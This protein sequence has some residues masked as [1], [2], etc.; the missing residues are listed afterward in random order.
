MEDP[1]AKAAATAK[2]SQLKNSLLPENTLS[3]RFT[4]TT[5]PELK[6]VSGTVYAGTYSGEE[7]RLLWVK[8]ADRLYPTGNMPFTTT[9]DNFAHVG[10]FLVYT[11]WRNPGIVPLLHTYTVVIEKLQGG[12]DLMTP[13]LAGGPPFPEK[14]KKGAIVAVASVDSPSV[15]LVI[16]TCEIDI[17]NLEQVQGAKGHAVENVHWA[18]DELWSWSSAGKPG[19]QPPPTIDGWLEG[20]NDEAELATKTQELD[21][22]DSASGG[23]SLDSG[24]TTAEGGAEKGG[25]S[26]IDD[27]FEVV[28]DTPLS[29]EGETRLSI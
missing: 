14:A 11:L 15:P 1:E 6:Q 16:G 7:Q 29:P 23:V 2:I 9:V 21:L 10:I 22:G 25:S 18:G 27:A 24:R 12:A 28:D 8:I 4:T 19:T 26:A 5:G 17:S 13:G 20:D 3:A